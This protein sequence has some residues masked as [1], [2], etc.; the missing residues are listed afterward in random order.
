MKARAWIAIPLPPTST[1]RLL[2][3]PDDL[4]ADYTLLGSLAVGRA[5]PPVLSLDA[6][7]RLLARR[8]A[9]ALRAARDGGDQWQLLYALY[10]KMTG[11]QQ[12]R[13]I[14]YASAMFRTEALPAA[15]EESR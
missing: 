15:A 4:P 9:E 13:L 12:R 7:T 14:E 6:S 2:R 3:S 8:F 10:V 11:E 1:W 5:D